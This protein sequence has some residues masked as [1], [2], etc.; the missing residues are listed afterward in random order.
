MK[1]VLMTYAIRKTIP[2][3]LSDEEYEALHDYGNERL[4][5]L[6]S[7]LEDTVKMIDDTGTYE[8][9]SFKILDEDNTLIAEC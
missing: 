6:F 9:M 5:N 8:E 1:K 7:M 2:V 3:E 4:W